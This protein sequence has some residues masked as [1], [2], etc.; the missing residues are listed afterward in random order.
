MEIKS[1]G[2][3]GT[4]KNVTACS[5]ATPFIFVTQKPPQCPNLIRIGSSSLFKSNSNNEVESKKGRER[6]REEGHQLLVP[7]HPSRMQGR[8]GGTSSHAPPSIWCEIGERS[9]VDFLF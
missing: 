5:H 6:S 3:E 8:K 1:C 7:F 2:K 4:P 9:L